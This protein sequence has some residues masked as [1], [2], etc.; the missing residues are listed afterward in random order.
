M[1][2]AAAIAGGVASVA[3]ALGG[4]GGKSTKT[5]IGPATPEEIQLLK[6]LVGQLQQQAPSKQTASVTKQEIDAGLASKAKE[7]FNSLIGSLPQK[8]TYSAAEL[9]KELQR[10][11]GGVS[12][13]SAN[14]LERLYTSSFLKN[15]NNRTIVEQDLLKTKQ[16]E[17]DRQ[18]EEALKKQ[19]E[20][21]AKL[22]QSL[23]PDQEIQNLF[24]SRVTEYLSKK[25]DGSID[26]QALASARAFVDETFT[27]PAEE[28][29]QMAQSD[30][31]SQ[32]GAQQAA[33][34]RTGGMDST[35][36]AN[37]FGSLANQRAKLGAARGE[38]I[39]NLTQ[40]MQFNQPLRQIG[41]GLQGLQGVSSIQSQNAFPT[42][43]L[44]EL[45]QQAFNN[46]M[47]LLNNLSNVRSGNQTVTQSGPNMGL[48]GNLAAIGQGVGSIATQGQKLFD[49][50]S[51][52]FSSG[53]GDLGGKLTSDYYMPSGSSGRIPR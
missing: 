2:E 24:K 13:V 8:T 10:V 1:P 19:Q 18:Y 46:R 32:L 22:Q 28:Q 26:P 21:Q 27:R 25:Q 51:R 20:E 9:P 34:G 30:Y 38:A 42:T 48:A 44:N 37:L 5:S 45:N 6:D 43:F 31:A 7:S 35:F 47:A 41:A 53:T 11:I 15:K 16:P 23:T 49:G 29:L 3:G 40:D 50:A 39:A 17:L 12:N 52:L 36:Q 4:S 33:L 14:E